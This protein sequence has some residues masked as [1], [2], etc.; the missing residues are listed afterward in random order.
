MITVRVSSLSSILRALY[1]S[2]RALVRTVYLSRGFAH[3]DI[4][5]DLKQTTMTK[6]IMLGGRTS[7]VDACALLS[8]LV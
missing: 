8:V 6:R 7:L 4:I 2:T 5:Q 3:E 1:A